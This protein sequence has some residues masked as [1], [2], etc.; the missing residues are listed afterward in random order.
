MSDLLDLA[1]GE[2]VVSDFSIRLRIQDPPGEKNHYQIRMIAPA[3][4]GERDLYF[5]TRDPSIIA[6]NRIEDPVIDGVEAFSGTAPFFKDVLFDGQAHEIELSYA[7][8]VVLASR[9]RLLRVQVLYVS[10]TYYKHLRS[11]LLHEHTQENPFA[12]PV[13]I[14]SNVE[15]GYGVFAGYS[16][17]T[18]ELAV[19]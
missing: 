2:L 3:R 5:S 10:E 13:N 9:E 15:N 14:Y 17:Q 16:S 1:P 7:E 6:D 8:G 19:E 4:S 18:F 11:A 12:E